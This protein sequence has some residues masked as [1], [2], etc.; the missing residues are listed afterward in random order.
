MGRFLYSTPDNDVLEDK[1]LTPT[2]YRIYNYLESLA[3]KKSRETFPKVMTIAKAI[4][5]CRRSVQYALKKLHEKGIVERFLRKSDSNPKENISSRFVV[6]GRHA[7]CYTKQKTSVPVGVVQL[8]APPSATHCT[9]VLE[10]PVQEESLRITLKGEA[11]TSQTIRNIL[12]ISEEYEGEY[13]VQEKRFF[14]APKALESAEK[15]K[16]QTEEK[17][18]IKAEADL[19]GIPDIMIPTARYWLQR[20]GHKELSDSDRT[21]LREL[22]QTQYPT[23]VNKQIDKAVER[24]LRLRRSMSELHLGYIV[25]CMEGHRTYNPDQKPPTRHKRTAQKAVKS[26]SVQDIVPSTDVEQ[27]AVVVAEAVEIVEPAPELVVPTEA[28]AMPVEEAERVIAE[29]EAE[30]PVQVSPLP[31]ALVELHKAIEAKNQELIDERMSQLPQDEFGAILPDDEDEV[32]KIFEGIGV[33][34]YLRAKFPDATNEELSTE[35]LNTGDQRALEDAM[36]I[37][38]ACAL[39]NN[40]ELCDLPKGCDKTRARPI[41]MLKPDLRGRMCVR[42]GY[43]GCVKCKYDCASCKSDPEFEHRVK[44][45]GLSPKEKEQT[46]ATYEHVAAG[47]EGIVAKAMAILAAKNHRNLVLAG[48]A[49]TGKTHLAVAIAIEAMKSGQQAIVK[50]VPD[51]M[52]ELISANRNNTDPFGVM[53]KYKSVPCLVLDDLGKQTN[54]EAVWKYL[55]QIVNYRYQY[56]LQTIVTTNAYNMEGLVRKWNEDKVEPVMSRI[57]ENGDWVTISTA[58]N[59]RV[60]KRLRVYEEEKI[61]DTPSVLSVS[62]AEAA[63]EPVGTESV[64]PEVFEQVQ[65]RE[66]KSVGELLGEQE[67]SPAVNGV[68]DVPPAR[69]K[70]YTEEE[71]YINLTDVD[72]A[73]VQKA[74]Y[75]EYL[76]EQ[77][78]HKPE[79]P[80]SKPTPEEEASLKAKVDA[81]LD[82][83]CEAAAMSDEEFDAMVDEA[84]EAKRQ[85]EPPAEKSEAPKFE[86]TVIHVPHIDDGLDDDEEDLRLYGG[87]YSK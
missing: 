42:I 31:P 16:T 12:T 27:E 70:H 60:K 53:M 77:A 82:E 3:N 19:T 30:Q 69:P 54:T 35:H 78:K 75:L 65:D 6:H 86:G 22:S 79:A 80:M 5:R 38:K 20:T 10:P 51:L 9:Q 74:R 50:S 67:D 62:L 52:D 66:N 64:A 11:E 33:Q 56:G 81:W 18:S 36:K 63:L 43:G 28:L 8:I 26:Q 24:W 34:D 59:Y 55:Y 29:H 49:G 44:V 21:A 48:K 25:K 7:H 57:L 41:A 73:L 68:A 84:M 58:E 15:P 87:L 13:K 1:S 23:Y 32:E 17:P 14:E 2:E 76:E 61:T 83:Q 39:C 71:W 45:C 46:F 85:A 40:P 4:G 37:D 47:A 72:K